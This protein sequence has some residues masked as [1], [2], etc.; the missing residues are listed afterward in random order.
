M[1]N[2]GEPYTSFEWFG[3]S[4]IILYQTERLEEITKTIMLT[5]ALSFNPKVFCWRQKSQQQPKVY[6]SGPIL[7]T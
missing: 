7:M 6:H 4:L 2:L 1:N 3:T 5:L